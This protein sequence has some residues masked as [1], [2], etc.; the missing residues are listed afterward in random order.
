VIHFCGFLLTAVNR[1]E[2]YVEEV[3]KILPF[4]LGKHLQR[5][6]SP[7]VEVLAALW[8]RAVGKGIAQQSRPVTFVSGTLTLAT[9]C[10]SWATQLSQMSEEL[11]AGLNSFLG[12]PVVKKLRVRHAP[13]LIFENGTSKLE[14]RNWKLET[15]KST[16]KL[17]TGNR[18]LETGE[19][20]LETGNWKLEVG[21]PAL[22]LTGLDPEIAC[23]IEE[24]FAKYF[25]R[26]RN[27]QPAGRH[28]A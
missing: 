26:A 19:S 15:G 22:E 27:R 10:P 6:G 14:T 4:I 18:K 11:R 24:A 21:R 9:A 1:K 20:K 17:E 28:P 3:G 13:N 12:R 7:L 8:P 16:S 23:F 5:Q 2:A 25:S